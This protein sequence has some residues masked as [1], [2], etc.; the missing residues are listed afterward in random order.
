MAWTQTD[1]GGQGVMENPQN[2]HITGG[3]RGADTSL[4][5]SGTVQL[6]PLGTRRQ[7]GERV[8]RYAK[9]N[10]TTKA[11]DLCA[12]DASVGHEAAAPGMLTNSAGTATDISAS[13]A[14]QI[15]LTTSNFTSDDVVNAFADGYLRVGLATAT[16][17]AIYD[18][19]SS[20]V[21][22]GVTANMIEFNLYGE[23]THLP[24]DSEDRISVHAN[25]YA[26]ATPYIDA[27]D[28]NV[29]GVTSVIQAANDYGWLQTWGP[30]CVFCE[31][32]IASVAGYIATGS[33][34]NTGGV[35]PLNSAANIQ[36]EAD[37]DMLLTAHPIVGYFMEVVEDNGF[38]LIYLQI[39]P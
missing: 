21:G 38:G 31:C 17:N 10:A 23:G 34:G 12:V 6:H 9:F 14:T 29:I 30:A 27:Q 11:G 28:N 8:F 13:G 22:S 3:I 5:A 24:I 18:I 4:Y 7:V 19:K 39:A 1:G 20:T 37:L 35:M 36:S 26:H 32:P 15:F 16:N 2:A 33:V 25:L